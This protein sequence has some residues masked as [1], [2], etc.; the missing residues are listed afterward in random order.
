[1]HLNT[2]GG[3]FITIPAAHFLLT[4]L[5]LTTGSERTGDG[6]HPKDVAAKTPAAS[7][8]G[9][10]NKK[11]AG[12]ELKAIHGKEGAPL[13]VK[14]TD[15]SHLRGAPGFKGGSREDEAQ[16]RI[17]H[18]AVPTNGKLRRPQKHNK[19]RELVIPHNL[20]NYN[21]LVELLDVI[22]PFCGSIGYGMGCKASECCIEAHKLTT[23]SVSDAVGA[24]NR[25]KRLSSQV[26]SSQ[27]TVI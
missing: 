23:S 17:K 7:D 8:E 21:S 4:Q 6:A 27:R 22:E 14:S 25:L 5:F 16:P 20:A 19:E 1:L 3:V 12:Q 13:A 2:W 10:S 11:F 18:A 15:Y 9:E 26:S 24:L